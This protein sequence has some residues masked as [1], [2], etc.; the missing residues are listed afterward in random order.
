MKEITEVKRNTRNI[1]KGNKR[2]KESWRESG[3]K[4]EGKWYT[5]LWYTVI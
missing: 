1:N 5:V 2:V 3:G 4:V